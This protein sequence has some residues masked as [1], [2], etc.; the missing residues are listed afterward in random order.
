MKKRAIF[1]LILLIALFLPMSSFAST[2]NYNTINVKAGIT[3]LKYYPITIS[4]PTPKITQ[5]TESISSVNTENKSDYKISEREI[6]LANLINE[7]RIK[8]GLAPLKLDLKLSE[9]ARLKS[10][11]MAEKGYFSHTS[12]TYGSPFEMM[13]KFGIS[14]KYAGENLAS[15]WSVTRAHQGFMNSPGHRNN[16][17]NPKFTKMGI[18][19][20]DGGSGIIV[21]EMFI[22]E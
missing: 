19:I 15:T 21:T 22:G 6:Q 17:L 11:D 20:V 2:P 7:E 13:S 9:I 1:S 4:Y 16:I 12:P 3:N 18:G 14:Y 10:K 5:K 8:N